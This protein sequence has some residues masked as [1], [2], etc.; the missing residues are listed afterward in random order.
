MKSKILSAN[1]GGDSLLDIY[2]RMIGHLQVELNKLHSGLEVNQ[3]VMKNIS[4]Q[5]I[6]ME[7]V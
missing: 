4:S 3:L 7:K 1:R 5:S 6:G 2:D